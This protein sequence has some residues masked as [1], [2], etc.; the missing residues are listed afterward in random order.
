MSK[1][2]LMFAHNN[3]EI[4]Y[5][6]LAVVNALLIKQNCDIHDITVVTNQ[7]SYDYTVEQLGKDFVHNAISNI[8]ITE[9]D[10]DFKRANQRLYKDTSHTSKALPFYNV[11]RCDAYNI[12]PYDETLLIDA[13]YLILSNSLNSCW[14]HEN[15]LMMNWSYQDIMSE[16]DD[17]T[18]KRLSPTGITMYWATVVYFRKTDFAK[19]FFKTV[20]HV[21]DHR[22]FYQDVYKWPGNLYR[23][24]YSFSVAAHMMSG[25]VDRGIPQL[26]VPYLYKT[27]DTD[28][29]HSAPAPNELIFYLEK[30][31]SLGDFMLCRWSG[32]D[33]HVMN[34]WAINRTSNV[35]MEY[36]NV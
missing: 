16:R 32:L 9:K 2:F 1:G 13:D 5:L 7:H 19:Q 35:L 29:I 14:G 31:K 21:R 20:A 18:L 36:A 33:I 34:K 11:D 12:S 30:P 27:F 4:D 3:N 6:K 25:F 28:D 10:K 22:E 17:P 15:E 24:D 8:V 26:P 23:N